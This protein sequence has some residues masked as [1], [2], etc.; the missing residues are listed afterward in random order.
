MDWMVRY[1]V[2]I[3]TLAQR[4]RMTCVCPVNNTSS[5]AVDCKTKIAKPLSAV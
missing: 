5:E 4:V 2:D 1:E 3:Y